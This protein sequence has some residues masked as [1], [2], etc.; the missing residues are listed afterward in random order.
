VR[1]CLLTHQD[2][3]ADDFPEDDWACDPRP[4]LPDDDWYVA[5]LPDNK[6]SARR[7]EALIEEG[8]DLFFNLCDGPV[9]ET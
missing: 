7:V 1:I 2:L 5:T 4:F 3:D 9:G 8:F 6:A